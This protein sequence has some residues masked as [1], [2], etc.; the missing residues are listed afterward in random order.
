VLLRLLIALAA[1][2]GFA[3]ASAADEGWV[4][5]RLHVAFDVRA[6]ASIDVREEF[7]VDFRTLERHGILRDIVAVQVYDQDYNRRYDIGRPVVTSADGRTHQVQVSD[8]GALRRFRIGDPD[9][10]ISG[11][12]TYRIAYTLNGAF[13]GFP[14]HDEFYWNAVGSWPVRIELASFAVL[15]PE[16]GIERAQCFQGPLGSTEPCHAT[17]TADRALF[18]ATRPLEVGEQLTVVAGL[19]KGAVA[20]PSPIL[21]MRPRQI[22]RFFD[23][24]PWTLATLW[25]GLVAAVGGVGTLWWRIGRDRRYVSLH[26]LSQ[27]KGEERVPILGSDPIVVEFGP[28]DGIRPGQIGLLMDERADTLDIT[29]TIIDLAVRGYLRITEISKT[30]WFGKVDWELDLVKPADDHLLEYERIVLNGLFDGGSPRKLSSLKNKFYD[31]LARAQKA[32]YRDAVERQWFHRNPNTVRT[33][34]RIA[35]LTVVIAGLVLTAWL[36]QHWGHGLAGLPVI[37]GGILL[38]ILSRAMPRRTAAGREALRRSLGFARYIRTAETHQQAF[39]ERAGIFTDYLPYAVAFR[40]VDRWAAAF[41]DIDIRAATRAWYA[42]NS[43]FDAG[44][45]SSTL[46]SFQSTVSSTMSSTPGGSGGSGFSGG[47][48]GGGGG[49]GGGGS[50]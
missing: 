33:I 10:T 8:E 27:E 43:R 29:S 12:E 50:W 38:A 9:R 22:T 47:S 28:P 24:T 49:G 26:Y 3:H 31:D 7:D 16:G 42:G 44:D 46:G 18:T 6:D 40:A 35:G 17:F 41:K 13:N 15:A 2:A 19:R 34:T 32:L 30:G 5:Q 14:G 4:I 25:V 23:R 1:L 20:E 11:R 36:G 37:V 45:F 39:A 48:S 21:V